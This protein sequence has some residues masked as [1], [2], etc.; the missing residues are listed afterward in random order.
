M[1][2]HWKADEDRTLW[3][4]ADE[5][6]RPAVPSWPKGAT[7]GLVLVAS[8]CLAVGALLYRVA[9]PRDVFEKN[10]VDWSKAEMPQGE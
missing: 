8:G 4:P 2:R 1:S 9:G 10:A 6:V 3:L 7:A 5:Q